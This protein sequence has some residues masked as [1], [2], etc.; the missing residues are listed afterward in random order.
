MKTFFRLSLLLSLAL[1]EP[2]KLSYELQNEGGKNYLV[3]NSEEH[4]LEKTDKKL[5]KPQNKRP[6]RKLADDSFLKG[7]QEGIQ[8]AAYGGMAGF[9][10]AV[11]EKSAHNELKAEFDKNLKVLNIE[12]KAIKDNID[13]LFEVKLNMKRAVN[14]VKNI[15]NQIAFRLHS[16]MDPLIDMLNKTD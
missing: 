6:K 12:L 5:E 2:M 10:P 16:K 15:G 11:Y 14:K 3:I 4:N 13:Q 9:L 1:A 8:S 7:I